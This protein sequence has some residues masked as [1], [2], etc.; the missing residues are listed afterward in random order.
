MQSGIQRI[1][2]EEVIPTEFREAN[3]EAEK[4]PREKECS[5]MNYMVQRSPVSL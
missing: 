2:L 5:R 4:Q 1:F 3:T